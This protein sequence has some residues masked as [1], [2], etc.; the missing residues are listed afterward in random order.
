MKN[1]DPLQEKR[2]LQGILNAVVSKNMC[3]FLPMCKKTQKS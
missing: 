1:A 3:C 2:E